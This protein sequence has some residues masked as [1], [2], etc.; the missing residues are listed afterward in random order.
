MKSAIKIQTSTEMNEISPEKC[1]TIFQQHAKS[2]KLSM[3]SIYF[4]GPILLIMQVKQ[5]LIFHFH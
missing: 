4:L 5:V 1:A 3:K 2:T